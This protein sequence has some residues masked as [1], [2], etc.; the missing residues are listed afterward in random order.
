M[1]RG[2]VTGP[3]VVQVILCLVI[4]VLL[5]LYWGL[6][7]QLRSCQS[8]RTALTSDHEMLFE[9]VDEFSTELRVARDAVSTCETSKKELEAR[10]DELQIELVGAQSC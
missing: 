1:A 4:T 6:S 5:Y 2:I 10:V 8:D 3:L 9:R 7:G